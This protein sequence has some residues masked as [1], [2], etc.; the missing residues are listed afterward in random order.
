MQNFA[1]AYQ[2]PVLSYRYYTSVT[3]C[4][5]STMSYVVPSLITVVAKFEDG[6]NF[7]G[8]P[9]THHVTTNDNIQRSFVQQ[10]FVRPQELG[11]DCVCFGP[12]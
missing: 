12:F 4:K 6:K 7:Y 10:R 1:E 9:H 3:H 11:L 5:V 2:I 8:S